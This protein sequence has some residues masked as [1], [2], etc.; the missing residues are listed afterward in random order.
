GSLLVTVSGRDH[1]AFDTQ[2]H[3]H[4]KKLPDVGRL[5]ARKK[6]G[7]GGNAEAPLDRFLDRLNGD[8]KGAITADGRVVMLAKSIQMNGKA[9][10]FGRFEKVE[11]SLQQ[12]RVGA[13]VNVFLPRDK[14]ADNCIDL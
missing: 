4:I 8:V 6:R 1:H 5:D 13:H 2:V 7:V 10:E 14:A 11:F 12:Q 3:D 9:Q